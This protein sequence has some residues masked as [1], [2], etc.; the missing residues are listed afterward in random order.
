MFI[1]VILCLR[2]HCSVIP[3]MPV[4]HCTKFGRSTCVH[5]YIIYF[6][7]CAYGVYGRVLACVHC[8]LQFPLF[9]RGLL[10]KLTC[11]HI[12]CIMF[13]VY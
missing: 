9:D 13:V 11:T 10:A 2:A 6:A 12:L 7:I 4:R 1:Y 3:I 5:L 8:Q